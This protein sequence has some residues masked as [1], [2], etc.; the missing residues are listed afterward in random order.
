MRRAM[1]STVG[2]ALVFSS[3]LPAAR[4]QHHAQPMSPPGFFNGLTPNSTPEGDAAR[5][6]AV[7]GLLPAQAGAF[8][9]PV[10]ALGAYNVMRA[11][12][13]SID[14]STMIRWNEYLAATMG[15][16]NNLSVSA[17]RARRQHLK[18]MYNKR[19]QRIANSPEELDLLNGDAL[20]ALL[21]QLSNPKIHPSDLKKK[22]ES[23]PGETIQRCVFRYPSL[24]LTI[25][26]GRL[27]LRD[28]WPLALCATAF[29]DQR[30]AYHQA[31][32]IALEQN[33]AGKLTPESFRAVKEAVEALKA[34]LTK[35][36]PASQKD[37]FVQ[38]KTFLDD[39]DEAVDPL[40]HPVGEKVL[41]GVDRYA[42]TNVGEAVAFVQRHNLR[43]APALTDCE[44]ESYHLLYAA[45]LRLR[46][47]IAPFADRKDPIN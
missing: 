30:K 4:A 20:N 8:P 28:G 45:M 37:D 12:A 2:L 7:A 41:A 35:T 18:E 1:Y 36:I 6:G 42:G 29:A 9:A 43:F 16:E 31:L 24:D 39:L 13:D 25:S 27:T 38:A 23:I 19:K 11:Q 5:I 32:D 3:W 40:R 34:K 15:I 47:A 14:L 22:G 46:D 44:G 26:L 33:L 17:W 10:N 21:E